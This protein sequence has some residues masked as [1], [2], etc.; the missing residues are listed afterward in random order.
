MQQRPN[1]KLQ[2]TKADRMLTAAGWG[3]LVSIW[4][5]ILA[6]YGQLPQTIPTHFNGSGE[7]DDYGG[8]ATIFILPVIATVLFLGMT[9]LNRYPHIF[10]YP[11]E[12]TE[13]NAL[14]QYTNATRLI[15]VIKITI[16][17]IFG[18]IALKD[19][20]IANGQAKTIGAWFL[21]MIL[22]LTFIPLIFFIAR[23]LKM[24]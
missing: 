2:P 12:I 13:E 19:I 10:N 24:K 5:F 20:Q 1:L 16:V 17:I 23:S 18:F 15:N 8:K 7:A 6:N 9:I 14:R 4:A 22:G 3:I 21:P 11:V